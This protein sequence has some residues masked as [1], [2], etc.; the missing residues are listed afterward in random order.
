MQYNEKL[1]FLLV[2]LL[3]LVVPAIQAQKPV[4]HEL[5]TSDKVKIET[6]LSTMTPDEKAGQLSLFL[7]GWDTTG[8]V[9]RADYL[10][11]IKEGKAGAIFNA[12][13]V[14][15]VRKLQRM[16]VEE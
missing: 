9:L 7:S 4:V 15:Y 5:S 11:L 13:T 12:Y 10:N 2:A 3:I 14:D 8:P 16:A 1:N 6:L